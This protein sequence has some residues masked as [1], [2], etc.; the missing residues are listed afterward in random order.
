MRLHFFNP[1]RG[2]F[3]AKRPFFWGGDLTNGE[4]RPMMGGDW[5]EGPDRG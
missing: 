4:A 5:P 1:Q 3:L 2:L